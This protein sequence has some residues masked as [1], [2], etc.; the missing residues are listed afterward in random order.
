MTRSLVTDRSSAVRATPRHSLALVAAAFCVL[1]MAACESKPSSPPAAASN[2]GELRRLGGT[3]V[4]NLEK[5][6]SVVEPLAQTAVAVSGTEDLA[7][8]GWAVDAE[9]KACASGVRLA[10]DGEPYA[11]SYG[12]A[13]SD[14]ASHFGESAYSGSGFSGSIPLASLP[15]GRHS[16][17]VQVVAADG[18][19]Y[20]EGKA[21]N[22]DVQ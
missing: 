17:V 19:G 18:K 13:R 11:M 21:V 3:A 14:V 6:G 5:I 10:V 22:I 1:G 8:V 2:R 4:Y 20:Y 12:T 15:K 16:L 9:A 7:V